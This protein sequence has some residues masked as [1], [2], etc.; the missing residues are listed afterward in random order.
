VIKAWIFEFFATPEPLVQQFD[1]VASQRFFDAY[2]DLWQTVVPAYHAPWQLI[3]EI[4]M[5]DHLTR[6]R[7][8]IGT[9]AGIPQEMAR[10]G[11]GRAGCALGARL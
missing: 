9:A 11:L 5:L 10:V 6:G 2:L 1:P 7:L 3:E 8:E 4:G